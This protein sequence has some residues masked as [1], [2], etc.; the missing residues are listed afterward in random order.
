MRALIL[1]SAVGLAFAAS[2]QAAPVWRSTAGIELGATR[3]IELVRDGCGRGW[4][5]DR[6]RDQSGDSHCGH[7]IPNGGPPTTPGPQVGA[8]PTK[9]GARNRLGGAGVVNRSDRASRSPEVGHRC[10]LR[11][12]EPQGIDEPRQFDR[13][14]S[15]SAPARG[16]ICQ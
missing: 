15:N 9:I 12:E 10:S 5:R 6:W 2:T 4:H 11:F 14:N 7:C 13:S 16:D 8:I 1:A 3:H